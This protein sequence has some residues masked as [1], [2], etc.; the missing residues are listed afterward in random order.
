[1]V[2]PWAPFLNRFANQ[3]LGCPF[4]PNVDRILSFDPTIRILS[5]DTMI[6]SIDH[7]REVR[8]PGRHFT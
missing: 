5:S 2:G 7:A 1:M 3:G 6:A 4:G 8:L